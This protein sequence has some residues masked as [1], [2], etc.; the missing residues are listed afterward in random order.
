MDPAEHHSLENFIGKSL[1]FQ[2]RDQAS[3]SPTV[4]STK[5]LALKYG[6]SEAQ[7]DQLCREGDAHRTRGLT[8]FKAENW[9]E[10][11]HEMEQAFVIAPYDSELRF[12]LGKAYARRFLEREEESDRN[13]ASKLLRRCIDEE[14]NHVEA[15]RELTGLQKK[16]SALSYRLIG[17][18]ILVLAAG[19]IGFIVSQLT[20]NPNAIPPEEGPVETTLAEQPLS[21]EEAPPFSITED[22]SGPMPLPVLFPSADPEDEFRFESRSSTFTRYGDKYGYELLGVIQPISVEIKVMTATVELLIENEITILKK[23]FE[24]HP[25]YRAGALPGDTIPFRLLIFE[26]STP[27]ALTSARISLREFDRTP[28]TSN[29]E[30]GGIV[31]LKT[32]DIPLP[33]NFNLELRERNIQRVDGGIFDKGS[34][35]LKL[36]LTLK[37]TGDRQISALKLKVTILNKQGD[38]LP[39]IHSSIARGLAQR[40]P[41][42]FDAVHSIVPSVLAGELR[43]IQTTA[44]VPD[45]SPEDI[46]DYQI[47]LIEI[48]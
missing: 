29:V 7:W 43:S 45:A 21:P 24:I 17:L 35:A 20:A 46:G 23:D 13:I 11:I 4:E 18:I 8:F 5:A 1:D 3:T 25:S 34:A 16:S 6:L 32:T 15:I 26:S 10:A 22:T 44:Y 40:P 37:N 38:E 36:N 14:P 28:F 31:P 39:L 47:S 30:E 12:A 48:E 2:D 27:P 41:G 19:I 42:H 9:N 33:P